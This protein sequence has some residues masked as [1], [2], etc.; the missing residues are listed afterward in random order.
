VT[1]ASNTVVAVVTTTIITVVVV[2]VIADVDMVSWI[3][4]ASMINSNKY[5]HHSH[6]R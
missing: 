5:D 3:S 6:D 2:A 1:A 4:G